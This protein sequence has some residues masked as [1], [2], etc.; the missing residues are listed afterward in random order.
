MWE[1]ELY[2]QLF[3]ILEFTSDKVIEFFTN[4]NHSDKLLEMT[5]EWILTYHKVKETKNYSPPIVIQPE[6]LDRG[7]FHIHQT[8]FAYQTGKKYVRL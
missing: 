4:A 5:I 8:F 6:L 3:P 2:E 1:K 7:N